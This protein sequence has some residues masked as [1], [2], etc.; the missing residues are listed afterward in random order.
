MLTVDKIALIR[1]GYFG[2]R[3]PI[4]EIVRELAVS[5]KVVRKVVRSGATEFAYRR[6]VQPRR[7]L[8][9]F[10]GRLEALLAEDA[11]RPRRDRL[12]LRRL[13]DLLRQEGYAGGYDAVW[14]SS[15]GVEG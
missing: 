2:D 5:R 12:T 13:A 6:Q 1:R 8:G 9:A 7:Q 15:R 3:K 11:A 4:K 14:T 10:A